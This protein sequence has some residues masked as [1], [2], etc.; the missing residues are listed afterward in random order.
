M[1]VSHL[2]TNVDVVSMIATIAFKGA[3]YTS[4]NLKRL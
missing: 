3:E 1:I 4:G 2:T